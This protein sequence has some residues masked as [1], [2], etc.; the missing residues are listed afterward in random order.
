MIFED[1]TFPRIDIK[2]RLEE[3]SVQFNQLDF[4][5]NIDLLY[6]GWYKCSGTS[7]SRPHFN[8][9]KFHYT[10]HAYI[11]FRKFY[12]RLI[13]VAGKLIEITKPIKGK[14][15]G[16]DHIYKYS[17]NSYYYTTRLFEQYTYPN[18]G[19]IHATSLV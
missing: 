8:K 10:S 15:I 11:V 9:S 6:L 16:I 5:D 19:K 18:T 13:T 2:E 14:D 7:T 17:E 1:D 12:D 3:L 4:K